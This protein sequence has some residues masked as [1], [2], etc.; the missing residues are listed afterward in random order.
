MRKPKLPTT[1]L[2]HIKI[3]ESIEYIL[4]HTSTNGN[5]FIEAMKEFD[6]SGQDMEDINIVHRKVRRIKNL[7]K[8][9]NW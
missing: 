6:I 4:L 8:V 3:K 2:Q 7:N 9:I 5:T 1:N